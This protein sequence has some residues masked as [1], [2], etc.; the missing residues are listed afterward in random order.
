MLKAHSLFLLFF[1]L[2]ATGVAQQLDVS[3]LDRSFSALLQTDRLKHGT[4]SLT[5]TNAATGEVLYSKNSDMAMAPASTLKTL[6]SILGYQTLGDAYTWDTKLMYSGQIRNG[7]LQGDLIIVGGGDPTLGS[8]RY[9]QAKPEVLL[10]R[11]VAAVRNAGIR[12]IAG[13]VI[14]D[15][16]L[17]GSETIP[18]G[19]IWQDIGNYYGGGASSLSW[20]ENQFGISITPGRSAGSAVSVRALEQI[21]DLTIVN[22][23]V[24]GAAGSGDNVYAYSA[25]FTNIVY[26]RGTY[27]SDLKKIVRLSLPDPAKQLACTLHESLEAGGIDITAGPTTCRAL[28]AKGVLLPNPGNTIDV[29]H[30]PAYAEVVYWLNQKSINLYAENILKTIALKTYGKASFDN[31]SKALAK[32]VTQQLKMDDTAISV[33]DGSGLSPENRVTTAVMAGSLS[34]AYRQSWFDSFYRSLPLYNGLK[35]KSGSI[36]NVLCYAGVQKNKG[37]QPLCFS[38]ITNNYNGSTTYIKSR[39]FNVLDL[40]K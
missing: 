27:A 15:D 19:W 34:F 24:T 8:D 25:P 17:F 38:I 37:G 36:R 18:Q 14:G 13:R 4:A 23:V 33:L 16:S 26:L 6:T 9:T 35:M 11:W 12:K 29:Y 32:F 10:R 21:D 39:L 20:C 31:G 30:S 28:T 1:F 22:E 5:V 40:L 2:V 3:A 7:I